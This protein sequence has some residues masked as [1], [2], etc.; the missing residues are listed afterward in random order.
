MESQ[1]DGQCPVP[2]LALEIAAVL[3]SHRHP[4][5]SC[6]QGSLAATAPQRAR[7]LFPFIGSEPRVEALRPRVSEAAWVCGHSLGTSRASVQ[8]MG[9]A[10]C[11][12]GQLIKHHSPA[13]EPSWSSVTFV[14]Q[15]SFSA[16]GAMSNKHN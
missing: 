8:L 9:S 13:R 4:R 5:I 11:L 12:L 7:A 1:G 3:G 14:H 15:L 16:R 10:G 2:A 6:H